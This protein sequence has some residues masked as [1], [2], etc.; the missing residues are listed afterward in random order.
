M[1]RGSVVTGPADAEH[2]SLHSWHVLIRMS[3]LRYKVRNASVH[4]HYPHS[5]GLAEGILGRLSSAIRSR[6]VCAN[7]LP[8]DPRVMLVFACFCLLLGCGGR[9]GGEGGGGGGLVSFCLTTSITEQSL[10][11]QCYSLLVVLH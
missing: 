2:R 7:A 6:L 11:W 3:A 8:I 4:Y 1:K 10:E 9:L 5:P